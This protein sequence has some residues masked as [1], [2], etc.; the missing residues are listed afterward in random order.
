MSFEQ[1]IRL[2]QIVNKHFKNE[3]DGRILVAEIESVVDQKVESK[4]PILATK[5]DIQ[6]EFSDN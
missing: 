3:D 4:F 6:K 5:K 1:S 2:F